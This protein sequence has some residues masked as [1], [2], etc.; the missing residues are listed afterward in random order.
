MKFKLKDKATRVFKLVSIKNS[1][2]DIP[3]V[4]SVEKVQ[5]KNNTF[6]VRAFIPKK[7]K[8]EKKQNS[9]TTS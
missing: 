3:E 1:F 7:K 4:I 5:G 2:S 9:K 8:N 6:L